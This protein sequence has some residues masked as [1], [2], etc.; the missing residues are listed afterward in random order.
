MLKR[1][2]NLDKGMEFRCFVRNDA[3]VAISQRDVTAYY[4]YLVD[5]TETAKKEISEFFD[6][7]VKLVH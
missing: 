2:H 1:W 4:E 3:L 6:L 5:I 7:K